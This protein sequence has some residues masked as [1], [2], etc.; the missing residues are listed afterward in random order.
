[1]L[2]LY[3][4]NGG[5]SEGLARTIAGDGAARG[6]HTR[7]ASLD[8]ATADLPTAGPVVIVTS[9]YNGTPPDN[10]KRFVDWLTT[11][12]PDLSGVEYLVLGCGSLD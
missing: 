6:W 8:E 9:S 5:S 2:V 1:M 7:V 11:T 4:S 12:G 3:G 10:A